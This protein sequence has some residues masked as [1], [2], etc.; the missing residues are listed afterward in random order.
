MADI[1]FP[2][3]VSVIIC[4][5]DSANRLPDTLKHLAFQ[6]VPDSVSWEVIIVNNNSSDN[7]TGVAKAEWNKYDISIPL[8]IVDE[9]KPGLSNARN[10]GA[11]EATYELLL[12]CDDDNWLEKN[13]IHYA[14]KIMNENKKIGVL[15]GRSE[16]VFETGKPLWFDRFGQAYAIGKPNKTSGSVNSRTFVAGAGM[17]IRKSFFK[18]LESLAFKPLLTGRKGKQVCSGED[19]ELCLVSLFLGYDLYYDERLQFIH[20]MPAFRLSWK[21]CVSLVSKGQATPQVHLEFYNYCYKT[22]MQNE[23][24]EFTTTFSLIREKLLRQFLRTLI[25]IKPF[26]YPI[27]LLIKSQEGSRKEIELK[28]NFNK[29]IYLLKHKKTLRRDFG[30]IQELMH[31]IKHNKVSQTVFF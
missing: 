10:R 12:F 22:I 24:A 20:F 18:L 7:T 29:L 8:K 23:K 2:Y 11:K 15:G 25:G 30:T 4:C 27:K 21:Y 19:S 5:Y 3:G 17:I 13:Y 1:F 28:A 16:A 26:W 14:Y 31:N 9:R 6:N